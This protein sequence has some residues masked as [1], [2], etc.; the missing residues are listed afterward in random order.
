MNTGKI[1]DLICVIACAVLI[2]MSIISIVEAQHASYE[3]NTGLFCAV[4]CLLPLIFR[5]LKLFE[6]PL[7]LVVMIEIAIFLHAYGVLLMEYDEIKVWD[8][9]THSVSSITVALCA[10]YALMAVS[11]FDPMIN[12]KKWMPL[13]IFI[14]V[15]AFGAYWESFEF[16][17][18]NLWGTNMQYSPWDTYRDLLCDVAGGLVVA[19][20]S[21]LYLRTR[22]EKDFIEKL[23][24]HPTLRRLSKSRG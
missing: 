10:F 5:R 16:A 9:V 20:Y 23:N 12:L 13:F 21:Y 2:I 1:S 22:S 8:T 17:V 14:I 19:V 6:L 11:V 15:V 18:D 24:I 3:I 4:M 7:T